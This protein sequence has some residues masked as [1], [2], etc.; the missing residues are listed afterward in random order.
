MHASY[1]PNDWQDSCVALFKLLHVVVQQV[2]C[3]A[4]STRDL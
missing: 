3:A 4:D 1:L 2:G